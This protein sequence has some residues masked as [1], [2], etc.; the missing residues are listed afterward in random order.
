[1]KKFISVILVISMLMVL[2]ACGKNENNEPTQTEEYVLPTQIIDADI[3]LPYT[4]SDVFYPYSAKSGYNRDLIPVI[5]E[6]LFTPT[7]DGNALPQLAISGTIEGKRVTVKLLSGVKFTDGVL[8]TAD[9]V[10][11]S[12]DRAKSNAYYKASLSNV[13]S[14]TV[15]DKYTIVFNLINPDYMALNVLTFPIIR[16]SGKEYIGSGKYSV[17]Y[18]DDIPYLQVNVNHRDFNVDWNKQIALCDMAGV[19]SPVYPFKAN[20][21][22]VYKN[23][24]S[25]GTY[26]NL[27]SKT[28]SQNTNN[29]VY[30]GVN[31]KWQGSVTCNK[32]VRQAINI[33][34]DRSVI[35][36][37]SFLGQG[38]PT[39][40]PF[41]EQNYRLDLTNIAGVKG[42]TEKA[43]AI[44]ERNGYNK[45][46][47][48]GFRTNGSNTLSV[49]ILVCSQN[50]Y[51]LHVAEA[52]K[53]SLVELGFNAYIVDKKT[54]EEFKKAL[55]EGHYGLYI[56]ET[57]MTDNCDM[58]GFFTENGATSYGVDSEF[59]AEY[60]AY[61]SG[62]L[63][64]T[65]FAESLV[66]NV[67][68]ISLFY[69]KAVISV[70]PN[71]IGID[72]TGNVYAGVC[73]WKV[74]DNI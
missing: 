68:I 17:E 34:I 25:G 5:Y 51:K 15:K 28:I 16:L 59:F 26:T 33:G 37:S 35:T 9:Y 52:L 55:S 49:S 47:D 39:V 22:S 32:W 46:N 50:Q 69:R 12:Y 8:L 64:A 29:F 36:A 62:E 58:S 48:K 56:G 40:T 63:S 43:V 27:S 13:S 3:S 7:L 31:S 4:S 24:L 20:E 14:V 66:T 54:E 38:V 65:E 6:S 73:N 23:D 18:L 67:P 60:S 71:V 70:N 74:S 19:S 2:C 42:D 1:M 41:R 53:K 11:V 21:I 45:V 10:K 61:R 57:V 30:V 44:L 72:E